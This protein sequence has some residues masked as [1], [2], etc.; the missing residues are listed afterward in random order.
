ML[1]ALLD[2]KANFERISN[3]VIGYLFKLGYY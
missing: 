3:L 1:F 2:F